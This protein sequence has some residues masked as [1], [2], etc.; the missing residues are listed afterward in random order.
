MMNGDMT[1][2]G[3][4]GGAGGAWTPVLVLVIVVLVAWIVIQRRK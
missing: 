4:M 2:W 3:W 1:G